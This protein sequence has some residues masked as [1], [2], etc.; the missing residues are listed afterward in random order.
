[1]NSQTAD[2][3]RAARLRT[4]TP[5]RCVA[6]ATA[7]RSAAAAQ[8]ARVRIN[9]ASPRCTA[10]PLQVTSAPHARVVPATAARHG[11]RYS[12]VTQ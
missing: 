5:M 2:L 8:C 11:G 7:T 6:P 10:L 3:T 12:T 9:V 4:H 1:M